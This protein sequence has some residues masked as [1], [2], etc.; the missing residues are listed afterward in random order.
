MV[1][2]VLGIR[3]SAG[4]FKNPQGQTINYDNYLLY[5]LV[6]NN[7]YMVGECYDTKK[8]SAKALNSLMKALGY[9]D[10]KLLLNKNINLDY[11]PNGKLIDIQII[12]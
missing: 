9:A 3:H 10:V 2:K 4:E 11:D 8:V 12:R 5:H 1:I 7:D 6:K